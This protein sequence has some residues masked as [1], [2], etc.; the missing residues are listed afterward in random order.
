VFR[1][2]IVNMRASS[3]AA[4]DARRSSVQSSA[5]VRRSS[6][7]SAADRRASAERMEEIRKKNAASAKLL[8]LHA[9]F[10]FRDLLCLV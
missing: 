9:S 4:G 1:P 5:G 7:S 3:H 10:V 6:L 8:S 2:S